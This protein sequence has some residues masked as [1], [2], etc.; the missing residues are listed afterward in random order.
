M[1]LSW[2]DASVLKQ[3][4]PDPNRENAEMDEVKP[5]ETR[6]EEFLR[7]FSVHSQRIYEFIL[8]LLIRRADADEVFQETC[9]VLWNKFGSYDPNGSFYA[10]ACKIAYLKI[11]ALRRANRRLHLFS[12]EVLGI[13]ADKALNNA[14]E[15]GL[16]REALDECLERLNVADRKLIEQR[17]YDRRTPKEIAATRSRSVYSVYR[18]LCRVHGSLFEC[19]ENRL[20]KE[21]V[22]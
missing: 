1:D 2:V 5:A 21:G 9:L 15:L 7:L 10:W 13:L 16:R 11:L 18:A 22:Q 17:Y 12:E 20:L 3:G 6:Q 19:V 14:D 4:M 8:M